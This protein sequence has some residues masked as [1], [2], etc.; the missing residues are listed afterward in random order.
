MQRNA[1]T[2]YKTQKAGDFI[3]FF[4][5]H[6][7]VAVPKELEAFLS[8]NPNPNTPVIVEFKLKN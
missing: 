8:S 7:A 4:S 3:T 5:Q 6:K 1:N 2:F